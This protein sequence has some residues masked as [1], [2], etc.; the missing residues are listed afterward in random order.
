MTDE[1]QIDGTTHAEKDSSGNIV[2][3]PDS[4]DT[5]DLVIGGTLY[6]EDANSPID[7][8]S[9]ASTQYTVSGSYREVIIIPDRSELGFDQVQANG[10]TG[11][12]YNYLDE[13]DTQT[14]GQTEWD[15]P[16]AIEWQYLNIWDERSGNSFR[17]AV[18]QGASATGRTIRGDNTNLGGTI[19]TITFSDSGGTTRN[20]KARV[21]GRVISI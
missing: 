17:M 9:T 13:S 21:Y 16:R 3:K 4:V 15:V 7:V 20:F 1:K 6:E 18:P 8:S 2:H 5:D 10:D 11:S 14:T 19:N 12:N